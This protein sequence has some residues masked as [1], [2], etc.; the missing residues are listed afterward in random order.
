MT[1]NTTKTT[2]TQ[3]TAAEWNESATAANKVTDS[4]L[5]AANISDFDTEVSNNASVTANTAKV[6]YPSADSTKVGFISVTQTVDLDTMESDITTNNAK[7][8]VTTEITASSVDTL[9]NKTI[10]EDGVGNSITNIA[11]A[12]IKTAAAID[13]TK[14]ADGTVTNTEFQY[15]NT[16]SSNA[17]TQINTKGTMSN[18]VEDTTPQFGADVDYNSNGVKIVGQTVGGA[19]GNVVRL[20]SSNTWST[21]DASAEGTCKTA[22]GIRISATEVLVHGVYTTSGLTAGNLYFVSET[23]GAITTTAPTTS[24]S[25]VRPIAY[26]LTT[27]ELYVFPAGSYVE[28]A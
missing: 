28:N 2:G 7:V 8:G 13:A 12:S 27:T 25:I 17:Q 10:D 21:A 4:T 18:I 14:I 3:V 26:A 16:L 22:L 24:L 1:L 15:I 19:N 11:N 20:S 5:V 6:T 9:T 23:A